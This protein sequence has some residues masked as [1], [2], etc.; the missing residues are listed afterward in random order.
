MARIFDKTGYVSVHHRNGKGYA[1]RLR[2]ASYDH[3]L[4]V[5]LRRVL[6]TGSISREQKQRRGYYR[7]EVSSLTGVLAALGKMLPYLERKRSKAEEWINDYRPFLEY[8]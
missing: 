7:L 1:Y 3:R 6:G 5:A 2:F 8:W 4:L